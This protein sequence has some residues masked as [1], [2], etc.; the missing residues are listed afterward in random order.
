MIKENP[1]DDETDYLDLLK[2]GKAVV[3]QTP[4]Q[5][6]PTTTSTYHNLSTSHIRYVYNSCWLTGVAGSGRTTLLTFLISEWLRHKHDR[7][8]KHLEEYDIVLRIV[9]WEKNSTLMKEFVQQVFPEVVMFRHH[10]MTFLMECNVLFLIDELNSM[11]DKLLENI[12][13]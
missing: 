8:I 3:G 9:C 13:N 7:L 6:D 4:Q 12:L 1:N 5:L 11:S 2:I 10:T